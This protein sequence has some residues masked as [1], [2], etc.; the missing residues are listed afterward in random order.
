[1]GRAASARRWAR[2]TSSAETDPAMRVSSVLFR[3][4]WRVIVHG[5]QIGDHVGALLRLGET[6]ER[7]LGATHESLRLEDHVVDV[8]VVP[9]A[10]LGLQV[11]QIAESFVALLLTAY[12]SPLFPP[13]PLLP[14]LSSR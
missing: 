9:P 1:M 4:R 7:H 13:L 2:A 14:P 5:A 10:A 8:F 6:G 3:Q 12:P 11:P